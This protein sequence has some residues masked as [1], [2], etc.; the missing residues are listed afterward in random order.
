MAAAALGADHVTIGKAL[1]EDL[2]I[3]DRLP[4]YRAGFWKVPVAKQIDTPGF[5][6]EAWTP[7]TA[8]ETAD[9][10][11]RVLAEAPA[12]EIWSPDTDYLADGVLDKIN[13]DDALTH[14]KLVEGL[15]RFDV[16]EMESKKYIQEA[17]AKLV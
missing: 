5:E 7:P 4:K 2:A 11:A 3:S 10:I 15:K 1:L 14:A 16:W 12:S 9:H 17:Q 6:W 8:T 13:E